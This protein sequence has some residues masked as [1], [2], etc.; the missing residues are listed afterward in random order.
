M[1]QVKTQLKPMIN[2]CEIVN[3]LCQPLFKKTGVTLFSFLEIYGDGSYVELESSQRNFSIIMN[4]EFPE[5]WPEYLLE[6]SGK[7]GVFF[8]DLQGRDYFHPTLRKHNRYLKVDHYMQMIEGNYEYSEV[9]VRIYSYATTQSNQAVNYL[10]LNQ[11]PF[12][13][14]FNEYFREKMSDFID[15]VEKVKVNE[16]VQKRYITM[17]KKYLVD[18]NQRIDSNNKFLTTIKDKIKITQRQKQIIAY[19]VQ[20]YS[21]QEIAEKMGLAYRTVERHLDNIQARFM[22]SSRRQ[23]FS[24]LTEENDIIPLMDEV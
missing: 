21:S 17:A 1:S 18:F 12:F 3:S 22:C 5:I 23:L 10:Y 4:S 16:M 6:K 15:G 20:N 2:Q 24:K 11:M 7:L 9:V 8:S 19:Y 14:K 13:Q